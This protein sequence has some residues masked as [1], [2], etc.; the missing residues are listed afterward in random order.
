MWCSVMSKSLRHSELQAPL[1]MAISGKNT[2]VSCRFLL[3][4]IFLTQGSNSGLLHWQVESLP[5][6]PLGK[7][8]NDNRFL[9]LSNDCMFQVLNRHF[10]FYLCC[11]Q[12]N[13]DANSLK[14]F[15]QGVPSASGG[16]RGWV[17][18]SRVS[19]PMLFLM[20]YA[21]STGCAEK[22]GQ[23][24]TRPSGPSQGWGI[25]GGILW[26]LYFAEWHFE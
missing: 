26:E 6:V 9:N 21:A 24:G 4:G 5:L 12:G 1:P 25:G 18:V 20:D 16:T 2:E 3:Q 19:A 7:S 11:R 14:W 8:N 23:S 15:P 13:S 17:W 22:S 10:H